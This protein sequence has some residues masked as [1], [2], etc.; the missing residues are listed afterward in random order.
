MDYVHRRN[1][2]I[3]PSAGLRAPISLRYETIMD[4][5]GD[6]DENHYDH[7]DEDIQPKI[8]IE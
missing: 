3:I 2:T 4:V 6:D 8:C 5:G 7:H 1:T